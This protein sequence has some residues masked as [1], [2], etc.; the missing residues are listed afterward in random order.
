MC[1]YLYECRHKYAMGYMCKS[2][3]TLK[4][5]VLLCHCV[6]PGGWTQVRSAG[7][8][9]RYLYVLSYLA[10]PGSYIMS[11]PSLCSL[12]LFLMY[13]SLS[14]LL[15]LLLLLRVCEFWHA[16]ECTW[17]LYNS[18]ITNFSNCFFPSTIGPRD[19]TQI[20][21]LAWQVLLSTERPTSPRLGFWRSDNRQY[22]FFF[23]SLL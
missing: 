6:A 5:S 11:K 7:F 16:L 10:C 12:L 17:R 3:D 4:V 20:F 14:F 9:G 22:L 23:S 8:I 2:E 15:L 21:R 1:V 13:S 19:R 18:E